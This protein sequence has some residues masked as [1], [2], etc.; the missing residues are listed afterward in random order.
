MPP[1]PH[2]TSMAEKQVSSPDLYSSALHTLVSNLRSRDEERSVMTE[3]RN[4]TTDSE[5]IRELKAR[6]DELS[7]T[8]DGR[9]FH[10]A[11]I[12]ISL[13]SHFDRLRTIS[14]SSPSG[15][16]PPSPHGMSE[17]TSWNTTD[18]SLDLADPFSS[19]RRQLSDFQV[20]RQ[21]SG[22]PTSAPGSPPVLAVEAALLWTRIDEEL[23]TIAR[24]CKD[25]TLVAADHLPPEYEAPEYD[26]EH[27]P[28]YDE[29]RAPP[30]DDKSKP[31]TSSSAT[32]DDK[33]RMDLEAIT[34]AIDR[35]YLVA[36]QLHNQRVELRSSK[37]EQLE[38]ARKAGSASKGKQKEE[39]DMR[40]L[41]NILELLG[42]A[43]ERSLKD[44]SYVLEDGMQSRLERAKQRDNAKRT[45]FVEQLAEHSDARRFHGQ[46]AS[47]LPPR[48]RAP[49]ALLT[50]PEFIREP[51]PAESIRQDPHALLSLPEFVRET[52][53]EKPEPVSPP[54]SATSSMHRLRHSKSMK[55][56]RSRSMSM[57]SLPWLKSSSR[58]R[59]GSIPREQSVPEDSADATR[60]PAFE[61][62][63]VA[64]HHDSLQNVL[65]FF[66]VAGAASGADI[67]AEVFPVSSNS[68]TEGGDWLV[69]KSA[70][71][72][73]VP[74]SLP[75]RVAPGKKR[76]TATSTHYEVKL[77]TLAGPPGPDA[78]SPYE[79]V[80]LLDAT[81]LRTGAPTNFLCASCSLPLVHAGRVREYADLP[82]EYW[83][84]LVEAWMCHADQKLNEHVMRAG[85][86]LWPASGQAFVGGSYVLFDQS[87]VST[88]NLRVAEES[89]RGEEW[90]H[91]RCLCGSLIGRSREHQLDD[92]ER[93]MTFRLLKYAMRPVGPSS[94]PVR[95]PLSAFIVED[96]TE[97]VQAHACHRFILFDEEDE[98]PRILLW[99]F[100]PSIRI[101]YALNKTYA[102]PRRGAV[103][104]AK[105]L[106]KLLGPSEGHPD[107]KG[108]L[109]RYPGFPQAEYLYYPMN[110]CQQ[111][112][113]LLK[114]S[115]RAYPEAM[116]T[117]TGLD[118]GWLQRA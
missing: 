59:S 88:H 116:R 118:V 9:D 105:V 20:E 7:L 39:P 75:A 87:S 81:Q 68:A 17:S 58:S 64:E 63:Y 28:E 62:T 99:L 15:L 72:V 32:L 65:A 114:E 45:A 95:I 26:S 29:A 24:L 34:L 33:M 40:E 117:M 31:R 12:L 46:D 55:R 85:R 112:A 94:E 101:A 56:M 108:T 77:P 104:A 107:L 27:P 4:G 14:N 37:V 83:E 93:T 44:Q 80:P 43:S 1:A 98:Q 2:T 30:M 115:N 70:S 90:R 60:P 3:I 41:E 48:E 89:K 5:L 53:A 35:L 106:F 8:I 82:S 38:R 13:L 6:V 11:S 36:P 49:E 23:D 67:E 57:P 109:A 21:A 91:V 47:F 22:T 110:I 16:I 78:P 73:S 74:L 97:L 54:P 86:G 10:L 96:L 84:E 79:P 69:I 92:G 66:T 19:L 103:H 50:L 18:F 111:L 113:V 71:N 52:M 61:V 102:I 51:V 100:K 25:R 42:K 76:V